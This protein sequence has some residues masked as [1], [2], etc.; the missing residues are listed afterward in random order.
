MRIGIDQTPLLSAQKIQG[1][2][3]YTK[4]L[5]NS[6]KKYHPENEYVLFEGENIPSHVDLVHF[7]YFEPFF[8]SL[9]F[10]KKIKTIL[11]I[12]DLIPLVFPKLF[13][14]GIKGNIK[15]IIQKVL[16][17]GVDAIITDSESSKKDIVKFLKINPDKIFPILLDVSEVFKK[18]NLSIKEKEKL[19]EKYSLPDNFVLYVGDATPNKNLRRLVEAC[20]LLSLPLV[21]VG[22]SLAREVVDHPWNKDVMFVQEKAKKNNKI[23][24]LGF[25]PEEDLVKLYN[26]ATVFAFPSLYEGFGLPVLEAARSGCP[27]VTS[28]GGSLPEVM[29]D[30]ALYV[31]PISVNSIAEGINKVFKNKKLQLSLSKKGLIQSKKFSW[32]KT[33]NLTVKVYEKVF[34]ET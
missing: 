23:H 33:S 5:I 22:K 9:P 11:T 14:A 25:V 17:Q 30:A 34:K 16:A 13:P 2:G 29:N 20:E 3:F 15:F 1:T 7:P 31:D 32:E 10:R 27:V 21:I 4:N 6:L 24:L 26:I 8:I 19:V 28:K 12:H 18:L